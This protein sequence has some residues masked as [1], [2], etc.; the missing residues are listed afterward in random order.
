MIHFFFKDT[1]YWYK[2][3][4]VNVIFISPSS[5]YAV[6][7]LRRK[8]CLYAVKPLRLS[9]FARNKLYSSSAAR[10]TTREIF[11]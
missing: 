1:K 6:L 4:R 2:Y 8:F 10:R 11:R 5:L 7:P 3:Q 9:V